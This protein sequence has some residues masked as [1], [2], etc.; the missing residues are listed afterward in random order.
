MVDTLVKTKPSGA[1]YLKWE[2]RLI[3]EGYYTQ[4]A[5]VA[6]KDGN[7][8]QLARIKASANVLGKPSL[9][10]DVDMIVRQGYTGQKAEEVIKGINTLAAKMEQGA[11][12]IVSTPSMTYGNPE[13]VRILGDIESESASLKALASGSSSTLTVI[14]AAGT[15]TAVVVING[16]SAN[17]SANSSQIKGTCTGSWTCSEW[18]ACVNS[19]QT[20]RCTAA[21]VCNIMPIAAT[22]RTC[23]STA[24]PQ[25]NATNPGTAPS[26]QI[27][28]TS[29]TPNPGENASANQTKNATSASTGW[30]VVNE[31]TSQNVTSNRTGGR[32]VVVK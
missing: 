24:V 19:M 15:A 22:T 1:D 23:T 10:K 16:T 26:P 14:T 4:Q 9:G 3:D 30:T 18:S 29:P 6:M 21:S 31:S 27:N 11:Q 13:L 7:I 25:S 8:L 5:A 12:K 2:Q 32:K 28:Q 20:R 17:V